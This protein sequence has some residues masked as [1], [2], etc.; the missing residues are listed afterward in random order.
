MKTWGAVLLALLILL[1]LQIVSAEDG[2]LESV[3]LTVTAP[4]GGEKPAEI[5][6]NDLKITYRADGEQHSLSTEE[7]K[8][9]KVRWEE[10]ASGTAVTGTFVAGRNYTLTVEFSLFSEEEL[11]VTA[12][13][14]AVL[15][16][17]QTAS[18]SCSEDHI[19]RIEGEFTAAQADITPQVSLQHS[20]DLQKVYDG[21]SITLTCKIDNERTG[22]DYRYD[23]Y[24]DEERIDH[25]QPTLEVRNVTDSGS[26]TCMVVATEG[27]LKEM[28]TSAEL[29]VK[30]SPRP[31]TLVIDDAEKNIGDP[32]PAFTY[33]LVGE[34]YDEDALT[35]KLTRAEGEY[36]GEY[37]LLIGT[38]AFPDELAYN[39]TM[40]VINGTL[41]IREAGD[42]AYTP[43]DQIADLSRLYGKNSSRIKIRVS[44]NSIPSGGIFTLS[45][46]SLADTDA[47]TEKTGRELLKAFSMSIVASDSSTVDL[48]PGAHLRI[49]IPLTEEEEALAD[50]IRA[51]QYDAAT[52]RI[53]EYP[54][55]VEEIAECRYVTFDTDEL[56]PCALVLAKANEPI[57]GDGTDGPGGRS[58]G[59]W[60]WL[61]VSIPAILAVGAIV[62]TVIWNQ[63][64]NSPVKKS[65]AAA[66]TAEKPLA[67]PYAA[68]LLREK[69]KKAAKTRDTAEK[70]NA[71]S[72]DPL[73]AEKELAEGVGEEEAAESAPAA[74]KKKK[75]VVSF[76]D[77]DDEE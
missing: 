65:P 11:P 5:T 75:H 23:W 50:R 61:L 59:P 1:P 70:L 52:G 72:P 69:E 27:S 73:A 29:V 24:R 13:S 9:E 6:E 56:L 15:N 20:G 3:R 14:K 64:K 18:I 19:Y 45:A 36:V 41:T 35:G 67:D 62:F 71:L 4:I 68:S 43:V 7:I 32:D 33:T 16:E 39:Y 46:A 57:L 77:L 54:C 21:A 8:I 2:Y 26:Y 51:V 31:L 48:L 17:N 44:K 74:G 37:P 12:Q 66:K 42:V 28:T 38:L 47:I 10:N 76:D 25:N 30:I 49:Q 34:C 58:A 63:K 53:T 40:L 22:V 60:L 55:T